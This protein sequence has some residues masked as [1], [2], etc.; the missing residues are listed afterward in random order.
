VRV[1]VV[2]P[3][4]IPTTVGGAERLLD[5]LVGAINELT[6][7][8]A[9]LV[10]LPVRELTTPDVI[11]AY[12]TFAALDVANF[13]LVVTSKYPAW[14]VDHPRHAVFMMHPLRG[15]YDTYPTHLSTEVETSDQRV[16][17][18]LSAVGTL[19][20]PG[21]LD[22]V[23]AGWDRVLAGFGPDHPLVQFPGP[24][25]RRIVHALDAYALAPRR[26]AGHFAISRT[27]TRR[28]GYFPPGVEARAVVPPTTLRHLAHGD[29]RGFFTASRLDGPK[30]IDLLV[31]AMR[32]V[33][34]ETTLTIAGTGPERE[35]LE[36]LAAGDPRIRFA[37]YLDEDV[38]AQCYANA[39]A[40]PFV[41]Y[42]EDLGY[43]TLEAFACGT[44]VITCTDSGG[45]T[46]F[47]VDGETGLVVRPDPVALA[48]A[49]ERLLADPSGTREMG[50]RSRSVV[51][52]IGWEPVLRALLDVP[53]RSSASIGPRRSKLVALSTYAAHPPHHGG[54]QRCSSL[55]GK[56][57]ERVDVEYVC[58]DNSVST[59]TTTEPVPGF[60]Q[61][62]IP[63][64][65]SQFRRDAF[66]QRRF[67]IPCE[68]IAASIEWPCNSSFLHAV[69]D[70]M[71][72]ADGVILCHPYLADVAGTCAPG[73][74]VVYDAHNAEFTLKAS[75]M[76]DPVLADEMV[77]LVGSIE[78]VA[79]RSAELIVTCSESDRESLTALTPTLADWTV[80]PNGTALTG[81]PITT[82]EERR[83]RR[84]R[85]V[86]QFSRRTGTPAHA[87]AIFVGSY[88]P[89]NL[90]AVDAIVDFARGL[91]DIVFVVAG[92]AA[93]H[94]VDQPLPPNVVARGR[95][96]D[97]ELR[98]LL[99]VAD[100]ALNPM[101]TGGGTNLKLV[102]YLAAGAPVLTTELGTRG[103][104][105]E[106]GVHAI[107]AELPDFPDALRTMLADPT[108]SDARAARGRAV[109]EREYSW[110]VLADRFAD[111]VIA[112]ISATKSTVR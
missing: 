97:L 75:M 8:D 54:Q 43:I 52:T 51:A 93:D 106:H 67:D 48:A 11:A 107:V 36:A 46:E 88:H 100:V 92:S 62:S 28:P 98:A 33:T 63:R 61:V 66:L 59:T 96:D 27:V 12:R 57:A 90:D 83:A 24:L 37:G 70:A 91:G 84:D 95:I 5:G 29:S 105:I 7:H 99:S 38:L 14:M 60:T 31:E 64:V 85:W 22:T 77:A 80:V 16:H 72:D 21:D 47:V 20:A 74:P 9:E 89:P 17:A 76:T 86:E 4:P 79:V 25:A 87:V 56:L 104:D 1:G 30:R 108:G 109:V 81:W 102:E 13:D 35:R 58:F 53:S 42:D 6:E 49:M 65:E 111:A 18:L 101:R 94:L 2:A 45:P 39:L 82:G 78:A 55:L 34:A 103:V 19:R 69:R 3:S 32:H 10:K 23:W 110:D 50:E 71:V 40:V 112:A 68:D 15:L 73:V 26:M 41:P 44:P